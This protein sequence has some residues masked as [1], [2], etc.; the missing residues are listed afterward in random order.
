M[1]VIC[2]GQFKTGTKTM[3]KLFDLL[4]F[5]TN[6]NPLCFNNTDHYILLDK[7]IKYYTNDKIE[8]CHKNIDFLKHY[9][10]IRIHIITNIYITIFQILN[11]Y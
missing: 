4:G 6:S 10:T 11:L 3:A 8:K 1:K 9:K 7:Q 5:K 2:V